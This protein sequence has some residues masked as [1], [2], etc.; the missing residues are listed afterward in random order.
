MRDTAVM[1]NYEGLGRTNL[2]R[3]LKA[4]GL[5]DSRGIP[6]QEYVDRKYFFI[7]LTEYKKNQRVFTSPVLYV[8][9]KGLEY[10]DRYIRSKETYM[11]RKEKLNIGK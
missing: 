10:L 4:E 3:F 8:T 7:K 11:K 1:L 9:T 6:Y 5:L 2:F